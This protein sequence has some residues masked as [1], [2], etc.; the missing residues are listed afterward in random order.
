MI[1]YAILGPVELCD[2]E[3]RMA[4]GGRRQA[5]LLALLLVNANHA[6]SNDRV[7]D[8]L[9]GDLGAAGALKRL[10]AVIRRLR[11]TLDQTDGGSM[12]RT[13]AAGY[14]LEVASGDRGRGGTLAGMGVRMRVAGS[15]E[16]VAAGR[17]AAVVAR[18]AGISRQ[19]LYRRPTRPPKG[20][21]R[22][23]D[24]VDRRS[25]RSRG[26]TR[27]AVRGWSRRSPPASSARPSTASAC[28]GGCAS[29]GC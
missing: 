22:P 8:A 5:A 25:L 21:R 12:L 7:I 27:P 1:K 14:L 3:R 18:V 28:S 20:Q 23:L 29:T 6:L 15:L 9:W 13:V 19:A 16:L 10:Q 2:D 17:P 11:R 4:V 24:D 26:P